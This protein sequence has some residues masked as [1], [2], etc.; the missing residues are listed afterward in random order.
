MPLCIRP[1]CCQCIPWFDDFDAVLHRMTAHLDRSDRSLRA[2][3]VC[4][5][6]LPCPNKPVFPI[7]CNPLCPKHV[8]L[9]RFLIVPPQGEPRQMKPST[10][11]K[12]IKNLAQDMSHV[13][14]ELPP[15]GLA[16]D[17]RQYLMQ[18]DV[19]VE[20]EAVSSDNRGR[21]WLIFSIRCSDVS[22]LVLE[23][24]ERG[25][26]SNIQGIN[27]KKSGTT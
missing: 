26:S 23:L 5:P 11:M 2:P 3:A 21:N 22:Q 4:L 9:A 24:I 1:S 25:L 18:R 7:T 17:P 12:D 20:E 15:G 13:L 8:P 6:P 14:I 16:F 10:Q 27:A 19:R